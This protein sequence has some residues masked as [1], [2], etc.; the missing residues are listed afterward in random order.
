MAVASPMFSSAFAEEVGSLQTTL[1]NR[2]AINALVSFLET[3]IIISLV[4]L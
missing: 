2:V 4:T 3:Y 1:Q